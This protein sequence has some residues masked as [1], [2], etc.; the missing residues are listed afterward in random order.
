MANSLA[1]Y[2]LVPRK[3]FTAEI[4][5]GIENNRHVWRGVINGDGSLGVRERK[6]SGRRVPYVYLTGSRSV[7]LQFRVFLE[8]ELG[9][10]MPPNM[11]FYKRSYLFMVSDRRAIEAIKLLYCNGDEILK[12]LRVPW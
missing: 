1:N 11:I 6:D 5:G 12:T 10:L 2:D 3:C 8:K 4:K 9:L 7:W